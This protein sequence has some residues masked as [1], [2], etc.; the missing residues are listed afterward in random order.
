MQLPILSTP[1]LLPFFSAIATLVS[2]TPLSPRHHR[3]RPAYFLLAGDSTT[4]HDGGWGD[5]FLGEA[6]AYPATG[7]NYGKSGATTLSFRNEGIWVQMVQDINAYKQRYN[8][9]VTIQ[10]S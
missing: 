10:V 1:T 8:V 3:D 4:A 7:H 9:Y 5:G 6:V 2:S